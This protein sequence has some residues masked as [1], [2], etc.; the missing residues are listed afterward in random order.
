MSRLT[1]VN[2]EHAT[3]K[4]KELFNGIQN[5]LGFVPNMMRTMGNSVSLLQSYLTLSDTFGKGALGAKLGE[6]I[7]LVVAEKNGCEYCLSAHTAISKMVGLD[8]AMI[9]STR[10]RQSIDS[11]TDA[12]LLFSEILVEKKG[13]ISDSDLKIVKEAGFSQGEIVELVGHVALNILTN[14]INN[15]ALTE[16]DFPKVSLR[17]EEAVDQ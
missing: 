10:D 16:I 4:L 2:P 11:K 15:T 14:Y 7:A 9:A 5:K 13:L 1:A 3:G 6:Q 8:E 17:Q 12:A